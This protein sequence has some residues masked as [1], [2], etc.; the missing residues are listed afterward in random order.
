MTD[1][2]LRVLRIARAI[3][4]AHWTVDG[5]TVR[6]ARAAAPGLVGVAGERIGAEIRAVLCGPRPLLG[7]TAL[8][9]L[10]GMDAVLPEVAALE[11]IEQSHFHHLDVAGHTREVLAYTAALET[12]LP[13]FVG[14][15]VAAATRAVLANEVA[16]GWS[17]ADVLRIG[18]LLHDIAKAQTQT[19]DPRRARRGRGSR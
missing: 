3:A 19:I 4:G 7:L 17:G 5:E 14:D 18:A 2:P 16:G 15:E 1:D 6:L 11:G 8:T 9:K 13:N 10:G 12:T